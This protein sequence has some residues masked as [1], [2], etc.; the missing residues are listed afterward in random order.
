MKLLPFFEYFN[1][2]S[3][4]TWTQSFSIKFIT[5]V[6]NNK[7]SKSP[8]VKEVIAAITW[9]TN[10]VILELLIFFY[11]GHKM[12]SQRNYSFIEIP[13]F[14]HISLFLIIKVQ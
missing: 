9:Y 4:I 10:S 11:Y 3:E 5:K 7:S 8:F 2:D 13:F 6:S 12:I 14:G 1:K